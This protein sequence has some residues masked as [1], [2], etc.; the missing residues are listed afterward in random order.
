M[1][2]GGVCVREST[3][4]IIK[5][6]RAPG[7]LERQ[8][9]TFPAMIQAMLGEATYRTYDAVSG[10]LPE[11]P[12]ACD[13]YVITGSPAGVYDALPWIASLEAFLQRAKGRAKLVG[14]CFGHQIMAQAFG[15]TVVKSDKGLGLGLHTYEVTNPARWID[16][17]APIAIAISHQDQVIV[18]PPE[19]EIVGGSEFAPIGILNYTDQPAISFQCHPEFSPEFAAALVEHQRARVPETADSL[20]ASLAQPNDRNR[21]AGWIRCFLDQH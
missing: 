4:G 2:S 8:F 3:I 17:P 12:E 14:I 18:A 6:G 7:D 15:G 11:Q 5:T 1:F 20:V 9:G 10:A 21:V 16:D 19:A 13:A